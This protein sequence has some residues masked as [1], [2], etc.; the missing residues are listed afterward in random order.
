MKIDIKWSAKA[1]KDYVNILNYLQE[2]W[3]AKEVNK[4]TEKVSKT[5][6]HIAKYPQIFPHSQR[7]NI[8]KCVLTKQVTLYY[9][10]RKKDII[11]ITLFDTRQNPAK[12][13]ID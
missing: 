9:K 13:K 1:K 10:L 7:K 8:R 2:E 11:L 12:L 5:L 4:F 3:S 6:F